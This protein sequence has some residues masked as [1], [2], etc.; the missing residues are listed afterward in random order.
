MLPQEKR[1]QERYPFERQPD[2]Q[3]ALKVG[4]VFQ[5]VRGI[6]DIS[7]S[8]ISVFLDQEVPVPVSVTLE[9]GDANMRLQVYGTTTWSKQKA[10]DM[11]PGGQFIVGI[12]LLSPMLLLSMFQK[13]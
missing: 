1:R 10:A 3:L 7:N 9:Y 11:Q 2:G 6:N 4:E 12:E 13:Y 8:G 5:P